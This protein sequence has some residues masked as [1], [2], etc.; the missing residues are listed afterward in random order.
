MFASDEYYEYKNSSYVDIAAIWFD[1]QENAKN[2]ADFDGQNQKPLSIVS[3]STNDPRFLNNDKW[4]GPH[5]SNSDDNTEEDYFDPNSYYDYYGS[6]YIYDEE[7]QTY[8]L[9]GQEADPSAADKVYDAWGYEVTFGSLGESSE[10]NPDETSDGEDL[11]DGEDLGVTSDTVISTETG[12][13]STEGSTPDYT[14][15]PVEFDGIT[16]TLSVAILIKLTPMKMAV[17]PSILEFP[18]LEIA[19]T[20]AHL[21]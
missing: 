15:T 3:E 2:F 14:E 11:D 20:T 17:T 19:S 8:S 4:Y 13:D 21:D 9:C 16:K 5:T 10:D 12:N 6:K 18:I 7:T 1:N